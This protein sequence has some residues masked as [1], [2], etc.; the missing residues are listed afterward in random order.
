MTSFEF[1]IGKGTQMV[2]IWMT[3]YQA[4]KPKPLVFLIDGTHGFTM[5]YSSIYQCEPALFKSI[6][7]IYLKV[8]KFVLNVPS[9]DRK[10]EYGLHLVQ[11][12]LIKIQ[13]LD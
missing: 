7:I 8:A 5:T 13:S 3:N 4:V 2:S 1:P 11:G 10:C 6:Y 12:S 9:L